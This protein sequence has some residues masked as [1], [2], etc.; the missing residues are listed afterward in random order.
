MMYRKLVFGQ[1]KKISRSENLRHT[2][3]FQFFSGQKNKIL[4]ILKDI[5]LFKMH[6]IIFFTENLGKK[7]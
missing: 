1:I 7:L 6:K 2:F 3:I 4:C 5:S